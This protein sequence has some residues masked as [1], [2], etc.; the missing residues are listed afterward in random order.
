[1]SL[2]LG[3][4]IGVMT[5]HIEQSRNTQV[6]Q[7]SVHGSILVRNH[8]HALFYKSLLGDYDI[9]SRPDSVTSYKYPWKDVETFCMIYNNTFS[10][11]IL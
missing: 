6:L 8:L 5:P 7:E 2:S 10:Y 3:L 11:S 4:L 9:S 1:M